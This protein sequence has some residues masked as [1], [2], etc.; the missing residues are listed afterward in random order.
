MSDEAHTVVSDVDEPL[1]LLA[2]LARQW[3]A[4]CC[5]RGDHPGSPSCEPYHGLWPYLRLMGLGKTL[6][7][8]GAQFLSEVTRWARDGQARGESHR[9][10]VLV[11]GSADA[12]M[13]AHVLQG[14]RNVALQVDVTVLDQCETPLRLSTWYAERMGSAG[15]QVAASDVLT[16]RPPHRFDLI[17]TSSFFGY[18]GPAQRV[19]LFGS[20]AQMLAPAGRLVFSN[21][22]RPGP[23]DQT[24]GFTDA[25]ALAFESRVLTLGAHLP[26]ALG[27]PE[28]DWR[29]LARRY[30][31]LFHAHPLNGPQTVI[32]LAH[33]SGLDVLRLDGLHNEAAQP[34]VSGPTTSDASPYV[35]AVL[36]R[37]A[38]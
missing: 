34:G 6:S 18:F 25:Q 4:T 28:A 21:R 33:A 5:A 9:P 8:H 38:G 19:A 13:L 27:L 7:G 36:Q 22:L 3:A 23:E 2:P 12:S 29:A 14:A 17:V 1:L 15:V 32:D 20:Y 24:V 11:S 16:Y 30:V 10:R 31:Q 35:F 26:E 37:P